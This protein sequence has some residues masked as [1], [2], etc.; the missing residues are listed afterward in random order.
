MCPYCRGPQV[1][2]RAESEAVAGNRSKSRSSFTLGAWRGGLPC[3]MRTCVRRFVDDP[4]APIVRSSW[5]S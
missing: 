3:T 2:S 1:I 5:R 4:S